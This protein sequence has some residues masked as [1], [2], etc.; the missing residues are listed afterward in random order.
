LASRQF[1]H[2]RRV[3]T[4]RL[5]QS[6]DANLSGRHVPYLLETSLGLI[7]EAFERRLRV[8]RP[9][10]PDFV[11][12]IEAHDLKIGEASADLR[13]ERTADGTIAFSVM[14]VDGKLDVIGPED[15]GELASAE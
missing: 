10:L 5:R 13:F 1:D 12:W 3:Q 9:Q 15:S 2:R 8:A 11:H 14:K 7:P 4:P 6:G